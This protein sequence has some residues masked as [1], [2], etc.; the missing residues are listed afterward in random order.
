MTPSSD[1]RKKAGF[2]GME[3]IYMDCK[4]LMLVGLC[5]AI[6][7]VMAD[8][9]KCIDDRGRPS[10]QDTSCSAGESDAEI[11]L[12]FANQLD[13]EIPASDMKEIERVNE[14][15]RQSRE[16]LIRVRNA[17]IGE[18]LERFRQKQERC[19]ILKADYQEMHIK[20]R[21]YGRSDPD[22]ESDLVRRMQDA[23][24]G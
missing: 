2:G 16:T 5:L 23:C 17:R 15:R 13:M 1:T 20:R 8:V 3:V 22:A 14:D 18:K 4:N 10:Y 11:N 6:Q 12:D 7:P 9:F 21:R 24:S 19:R